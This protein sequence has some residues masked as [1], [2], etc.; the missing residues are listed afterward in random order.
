MKIQIQT[1][2]Q[3]VNLKKGGITFPCTAYSGITER[4]TQCTV[5]VAMIQV[6]DEKDRK[7]FTEELNSPPSPID[8]VLNEDEPAET[9]LKSV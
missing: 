1:T 3:V 6:P 2:G 7:A 5:I 4:G 9:G 8:I